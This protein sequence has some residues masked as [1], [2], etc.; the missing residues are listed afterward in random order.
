MIHTKNTLRFKLSNEASC[1]TPTKLLKRVKRI[2][3]WER[4][5]YVV[6]VKE[7]A[8]PLYLYMSEIGLGVDKL[9]NR[10]APSLHATM[11]PLEQVGAEP[12]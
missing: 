1:L 8:P 5:S 9:G 6:C 4:G 7:R 11:Q 10:P 3:M 2:Q 12:C